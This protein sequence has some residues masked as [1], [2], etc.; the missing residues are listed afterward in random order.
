MKAKF[1]VI[2]AIGFEADSLKE[3]QFFLSSQQVDFKAEIQKG[4]IAVECPMDMGFKLNYVL[5]LATRVLLRIEEFPVYHFSELEKKIK[6]LS[7]D[8]F[9]KEKQEVLIKVDSKKSKLGQEKKIF[10]VFANVYNKYKLFSK[11]SEAPEA[12]MILYVD[13][14]KDNCRLSFDTT[15][16]PLYK[17]QTMKF[18]AEAPMRETIAH[19]GLNRMLEAV[20]PWEKPLRF[21]DPFCGS[22]TLLLE[23]LNYFNRNSRPFSF[24]KSFSMKPDLEDKNLKSVQKFPF[25]E[26]IANDID[27]KA[28]EVCSQN[29]KEKMKENTIVLKQVD[30]TKLDK[31]ES[32]YES[33]IFSNL[34]YGK[35]VED[36]LPKNLTEILF[37][38]YKPRVM[39][40]FYPEKLSHPKAKKSL[41]H[42]VENG[43]L[44]LYL[45]VLV[46]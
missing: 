6:K 38:N 19:W 18:N 15:G 30:S 27:A 26:Y 24:E 4:G 12:A 1:F 43:G 14:F 35:R 17:R 13:I 39:G 34:P 5:K 40:L 8:K 42:S 29:L 46:F 7:L 10:Q 28:L 3:I 23:S 37:Q 45:S 22:G 2:T 20:S 25:K 41:H 21:V 32:L 44:K 36:K 16:E 11:P 9:F 33:W 31:S